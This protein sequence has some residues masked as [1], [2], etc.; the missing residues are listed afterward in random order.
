MLAVERQKRIIEMIKEQGFVKV[1]ALS[2]ELGVSE[3]TIRRDLEKCEKEGGIQRCYGG[4]VLK[5]TTEHETNYDNKIEQNLE[6][7]QKIGQCAAKLVKSK[8]TIYL[9][10]GTT[11]FQMAKEILDIPELTVVT[12]DLLIA[13][14]IY[15]QSQAEL[16]VIGGTVQHI[17]GC[18]HGFWA[19]E[20]LKQIRVDA[21]FSGGLAV[22]D[23]FE[24]YNQ[25]ERKTAFR[26][27]LMAN[28]KESYLL[29]DK[30]KFFKTS[31]CHV[32]G[33]ESYTSV[34]TDRLL[35]GEELQFAQHKGIHFTFV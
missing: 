2:K 16:I 6:G 19:E 25:D 29:V 30:S 7:K 9:D 23:K 18:T 10:A 24:L 15:T 3:M 27:I 14:L 8:S 21:S 35:V 4:A 5:S 22:D 17:L 26:K 13:N 34:I 20:M 32:H 11:V 31:L 12:N 1:E 28:T 33:L